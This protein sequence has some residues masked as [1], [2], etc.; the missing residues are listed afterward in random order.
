LVQYGQLSEEGRQ[1]ANRSLQIKYFSLGIMSLISH[2]YVVFYTKKIAESY[3]YLKYNNKLEKLEKELEKLSSRRSKHLSSIMNTILTLENL[4]ARQGLI[5]GAKPY[6]ALDGC[7]E[8]LRQIVK[9]VRV[10]KSGN[11]HNN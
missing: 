6:D 2:A 10:G 9:E 4:Y 11:S 8:F 1:M 7:S 5:A 3:A